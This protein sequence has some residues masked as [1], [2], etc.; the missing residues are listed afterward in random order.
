MEAPSP[1]IEVPATPEYVL[2]VLLDRSRQEW[3]AK[4][5]IEPVTL[6]SPVDRLWEACEFLN[7]DDIYY[8]T[9]EWFDL[10]GTN[11]FD[12]FF[13]TQLET[14]RDLCT[15][16]ASRATMPQITLVSLCG[17]TCQPASVFLAVR[18]LLVEA[19]ADVR[20]LAPST[21]LHEFTRRHTELFL[22][23][24]SML[25]PGSLPDVEI[26]DGGK[27][28]GD[29][30]KLLWSIPLLIGFMFKTLS[31]VYF[32]IVLLVYLV[33]LIKS[34]WDEEAPN[35]RVDFGELRTF[36]DLSNRLASRAEFQS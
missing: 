4:A 35:A 2:A 29:L 12:A 8:S 34:W 36:R 21:S 32:T 26:D 15:L 18:S 6:D 9:M 16:I 17:K 7:G 23:K 33:L 19:G 3:G 28:R 11:W 1:L 20:E 24:I 31:P 27:M 22:G 13:Y 30:L 10:W 25:G 14:A 5:P